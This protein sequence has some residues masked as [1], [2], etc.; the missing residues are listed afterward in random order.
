MRKSAALAAVMVQDKMAVMPE[1]FATPD[2]GPV[3]VT[4]K[5]D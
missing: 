4:R 2:H 3:I 5:Q 1:W